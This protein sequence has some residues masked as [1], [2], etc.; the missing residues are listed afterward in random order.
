MGVNK[1]IYAGRVLIDLTGD[2]VTADDLTTGIT[3]HNKAGAVITG[4]NPYKK[5][6][7]AATVQQQANL[8]AELQNILDTFNT[9]EAYSDIYLTDQA[10]GSKYKLYVSGGQLMMESTT[11]TNASTNI[12]LRDLVNGDIYNI[13]V[14]GGELI[15]EA[16][17]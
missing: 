3:A 10:T 14:S 11:D 2:N 16:Q 12:A 15:K 1:V 7:T 6:E 13:Y 8:I 17:A 9:H 5:A 4:A